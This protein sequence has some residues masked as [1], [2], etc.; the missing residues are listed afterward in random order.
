M[1]APTRTTTTKHP[2]Q[3][4]DP[5]RLEDD[6]YA[7]YAAHFEGQEISETQQRE[8]LLA[9]Y[10][11]MQ[12]FV[13]VGFGLGPRPSGKDERKQALYYEDVLDCIFQEETAPE[14]VATPPNQ[15]K[16]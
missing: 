15:Q 16:E 7:R 9:L 6:L 11:I 2:A 8:L 1:G 14:T 10:Q 13:D 5:P 4:S 12:A 3:G